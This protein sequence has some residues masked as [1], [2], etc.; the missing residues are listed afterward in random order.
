MSQFF[1]RALVQLHQPGALTA[2]LKG[3]GPAPYPQLERLPAAV[4]GPPGAEINQVSDAS[5]LGVEPVVP[6]PGRDRVS[7]T[8]TATQPVPGLGDLRG[9][10]QSQSND[11]LA[12]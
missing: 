2:L 9:E 6:V 3:P 12:P 11:R 8:W 5:V 10:I 4:F 1:D 7:G